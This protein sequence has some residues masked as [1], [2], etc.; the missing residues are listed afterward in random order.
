MH[1][2]TRSLMRPGEIYGWITEVR[3]VHALLDAG[4]TEAEVDGVKID[5]AARAAGQLEPNRQPVR[6]G[7]EPERLESEPGGRER[8]RVHGE[9]EVAVR[10]VRLPTSAS[11]PQPPL[12]Q[13]RQMLRL[14]H[15]GSAGRLE[16]PLVQ[17]GTSHLK[18]GTTVSG[19][20]WGAG[21]G[22]RRRR[23]SPPTGF[24][25]GLPRPSRPQ[26]EGEQHAT[27]NW[28]PARRCRRRSAGG[29]AERGPAED[30]QLGTGSAPSRRSG[31]AGGRVGIV[32][33]VQAPTHPDTQPAMNAFECSQRL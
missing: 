9:V 7:G 18:I 29:P 12:I 8:L 13:T 28:R 10:R 5:P 24:S 26:H 32:E 3:A 16:P 30:R 17:R 14:A 31:L 21:P 22:H 15:R 1:G 25:R 23:G 11:T 2:T 4:A 20:R 6:L 19:R 33:Q 27:S